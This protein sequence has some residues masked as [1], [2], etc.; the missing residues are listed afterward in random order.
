MKTSCDPSVDPSTT[1]IASLLSLPSGK[2]FVITNMLKY[3][4]KETYMK[5]A[6]WAEDTMK[7]FGIERHPK[8]VHDVKFT[9]IGSPQHEFDEM[10]FVRY[11]SIEAAKALGKVEERAESREFMDC[12]RRGLQHCKLLV[13]TVD[14]QEL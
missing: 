9:L 10:F 3:K 12:R 11:P 13:S 6:H 2:P 4:D 7:Q 14:R 1:Q 8:D 5:Y